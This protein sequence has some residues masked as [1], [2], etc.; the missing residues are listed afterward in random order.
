MPDLCVERKWPMGRIYKDNSE[1]IGGTPLVA[2]HRLTAGTKARVLAKLE[3]R[4]PAGSVKCR[5]GAAMVWDA[6]RKGLLKPGISIIE[7]TSGNTGIALAFVAAARGYALT[8]VMPESMS[9]ERRAMVRSFG[10]DL[11]LTPADRGMPGAISRAEEIMASEPDRWFC[12]NQFENP[13]NPQIHETTTGVEILEDTGGEV[14][15][16]VAGVGTGGTI[17]GVARYL[18]R[19]Q[20]LPLVTVAVEPA[21]S[22]VLTQTWRGEAPRPAPHQIQGIG[23]GFVPKVLDLS[24]IDRI[25]CVT[26][27]EAVETARRLAREEGITCGISSGA[28]MAA[29]LRVAREDE[30]AGK[31]IVV[32]LP[33]GGERYLSSVLFEDL[34]A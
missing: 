2:L 13:A 31:T 17:T 19:T 18:K 5:I 8:L 24:L 6:E 9:L 10:A 1:T 34:R 16:F 12:P 15:Y 30:A 7:A 28:A 4:N 23:A 32:L 26:D 29:A 20:G 22:P 14:H 27:D 3:F 21:A 11:V 33:D 25:E